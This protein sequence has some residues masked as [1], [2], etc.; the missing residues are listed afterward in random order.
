[1][2][3]IIEKK[4]EYER[5]KKALVNL[6]IDTA[7]LIYETME[8]RHMTTIGMASV[9]MPRIVVHNRHNNEVGSASIPPLK[10]PKRE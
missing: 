3:I 7:K 5:E 10:L 8:H 9:N 4:K 6:D 2:M 1:M